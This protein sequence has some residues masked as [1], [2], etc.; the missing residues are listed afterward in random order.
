MDQR[1]SDHQSQIRKSSSDRLRQDLLSADAEEDVAAGM[2]RVSL[3]AATAR[4]KLQGPSD[5]ERKL[6]V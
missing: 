3:H 6:N 5:A 2:D 1:P 4:Q